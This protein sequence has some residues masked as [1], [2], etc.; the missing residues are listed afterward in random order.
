MNNDENNISMKKP[1]WLENVKPQTPG[2][3]VSDMETVCLLSE[4]REY[5][6]TEVTIMLVS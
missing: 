3:K 5:L 4:K 1:S 6:L 2:D